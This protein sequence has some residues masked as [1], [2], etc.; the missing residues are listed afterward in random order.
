M[1]GNYQ[2]LEATTLRVEVLH[3]WSSARILGLVIQSQKALIKHINTSM[4]LSCSSDI[5]HC[6]LLFAI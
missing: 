4:C 2:N 6:A 5:S 1:R 3:V